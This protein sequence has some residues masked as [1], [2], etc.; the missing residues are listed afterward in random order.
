MVTVQEM[1]FSSLAMADPL[2]GDMSSGPENVNPESAIPDPST[3]LLL[4]SCLTGLD[5][6]RRGWKRDV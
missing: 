1:I 4:A 2:A 5:F 3:M 6:F